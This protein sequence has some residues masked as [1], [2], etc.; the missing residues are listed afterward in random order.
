M[1]ALMPGAMIVF[2]HVWPVL[3]SLPEIGTPR[4]VASCTRA[5]RSTERFGAPL[6]KAT[7]SMIAA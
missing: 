5:G 1:R 4:S 7:P 3:K 6:Q 2:I